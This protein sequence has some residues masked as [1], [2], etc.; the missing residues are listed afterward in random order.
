M[1]QCL[2]EEAEFYLRQAVEIEA[3]GLY[4]G[5][6]L[7][8][9]YFFV[10]NYQRVIEECER[11]LVVYPRFIM[12]GWMRCWA[13]EQTGRAAEAII[14]YEKILRE[15]QGEIA[16]RWMGYAYALVG[17]RENALDTAAKILDESRGRFVSPTHLA[18]L[19]AGLKE[20][21]QAFFYLE[22]ALA[23]RDPWIL[24]IAADPRFDNLRSDSRFDELVKRVGLK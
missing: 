10:R 9:A 15:P 7:T 18:T 4:N 20:T 19:Y 14:E 3:M 5:I 24:W 1:F 2:S 17:D 12:A 11:L 6:M 21:D 16:R 22:N 8:V 13:L 23:E